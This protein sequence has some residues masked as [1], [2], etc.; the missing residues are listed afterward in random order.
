MPSDA[1]SG[2]RWDSPP[3]IFGAIAALILLLMVLDAKLGKRPDAPPPAATAQ[4]VADAFTANE[5]EATKLYGGKKVRI[6]GKVLSTS[7]ANL[8]APELRLDGGAHPLKI[9]LQPGNAANAVK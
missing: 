5:A 6:T 4:E 9:V 3:V 7:T 2:F 8:N 1:Q